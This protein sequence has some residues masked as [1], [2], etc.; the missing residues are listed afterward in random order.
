MTVQDDF[1]LD[2]D[3]MQMDASICDSEAL[4]GRVLAGKSPFSNLAPVD[5]VGGART[6]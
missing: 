4:L 2:A 3:L 6:S 1:Y 5:R